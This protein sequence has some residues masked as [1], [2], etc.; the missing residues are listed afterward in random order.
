MYFGIAFRY[1]HLFFVVPGDVVKERGLT[2]LPNL[3]D[4]VYDLPDEVYDL[5]DEVYVSVQVARRTKLR[6][7]GRRHT[8]QDHWMKG[9][10]AVMIPKEIICTFEGKHMNNEASCMHHM[11]ADFC[12][13]RL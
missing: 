9:Q 1:Q 7:Q 3:P 13:C 5:P 4:E 2:G 6:E 10:N 12:P 8:G 11:P